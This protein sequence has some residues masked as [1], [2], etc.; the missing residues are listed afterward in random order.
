MRKFDLGAGCLG[1]GVTVWNRAREVGGD[2]ERVAHI[3]RKRVVTWYISERP[4]PAD[5]A[6]Y[7]ERIAKGSN[8]S[9]SYSQPELPVFDI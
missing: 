6:A 9:V 5:V 2:Y 8:F 3:D 1:N 7:V 4:I